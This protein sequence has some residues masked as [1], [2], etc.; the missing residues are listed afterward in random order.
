MEK[1][2]L[3]IG[4][5][6]SGGG[7]R[8]AVY[9]LGVL[10][11][12]AEEHLLG[13]I[14]HIS[15]VSG[16]SIAVG[17]LYAKNAYQWPSDFTYLS[18][19]LPAIRRDI[20]KKDIQWTALLRFIVSPYYWN[21]KVNLLAKVMEKQW[22]FHACLQD[23]PEVPLWTIN[24]TAY[25][26]GK[27]FR[28]STKRMGTK[29]Y[30]VQRPNFPLSHAMVASAGFPIFIGPYKLKTKDY[31]WND[32]TASI[33]VR[34]RDEVLHLWDG[35]VYDNMGLDP[36]FQFKGE[37]RLQKDINYLIVSNASM[38]VVEHKTRSIGFSIGNLK[39][40]LDVSMT[41][42]QRLR[43]REVLD[44]MMDKKQG[45]FLQIGEST[46]DIVHDC[47]LSFREKQELLHASLTESEVSQVA[48]YRTTLER[49]KEA[50]FERILRHGYE[51]AKANA[52]CFGHLS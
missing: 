2:D 51:V 31:V 46:K 7:M 47:T 12:L 28:I 9:H 17:L 37:N 24:T 40:L 13:K 25:E 39:R 30:F 38:D 19:V 32:A 3:K 8:A 11:Y 52:I 27:D 26:N 43:K 20:V 49:V 4:L 29:N 33:I 41:Q 34:I 18:K 50:D 42:N 23:I 16:A 14:Q 22:Q 44:F 1:Q 35:G 10:K 48:N 6:L 21:K 45:I 36:L 15:S 5:A